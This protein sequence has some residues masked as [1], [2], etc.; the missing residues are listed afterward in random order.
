MIA[1]IG[2]GFSHELFF[3]K[4]V[5]EFIEDEAPI[6][7]MRK[8]KPASQEF[9]KA[10]KQTNSESD[11]VMPSA[12]VSQYK[13]DSEENSPKEEPENSTPPSLVSGM[14]STY[15]SSRNPATQPNSNPA[16]NKK[17]STKDS[18]NSISMLGAG[19]GQLLTNNNSTNNSSAPQS[20]SSSSGGP[21]NNSISCL[22][23]IGDGVYA[24]SLQVNITCSSS[25]DIKYCVQQGSCCDPISSGANY[26][27]SITVGAS[28][29]T[30]CL[31]FF[32][33]SVASGDSSTVIQKTYTIDSSA[34]DLST[35]FTKLF[36]Q[37]TQ[38]PI[39][40]LI[41]S[42]DFGKTGY[43]V[44]EINLKGNDPSPAGLNLD[45][46]T[47]VEDHASLTSPSPVVILSDSDVSGF[48]NTHQINVPLI[49]AKFDYGDNYITTYVVDRNISPAVYSCATNNIVLFDFDV[50]VPEISHGDTG[51]NAAREFSAS[52]VSYGFFEST[53]NINRTPAGSSLETV[54]SQELQVGSFSM[55]Y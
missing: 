47:I 2:V 5:A 48:P 38:L 18:S 24:N 16:T 22:S 43:A 26:S 53:P 52:F 31:S 49:F 32:G 19:P 13:E 39:M 8:R 55:F 9:I 7:K 35:I 10:T 25:A 6:V 34:P 50:F 15:G 30:Y 20:P 37:T 54:S 46:E 11:T 27:S 51:T 14:N 42:N 23:D 3:R 41:R 33:T 44:G 4:P 36:L 28:D 1:L 45:C 17:Q 29:G 12:T 40:N 21:S